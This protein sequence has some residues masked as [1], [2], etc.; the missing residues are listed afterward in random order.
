MNCLIN[1]SFIIEEHDVVPKNWILTEDERVSLTTMQVTEEDSYIS[2]QETV[3]LSL[4]ELWW[5][6]CRK[7]RITS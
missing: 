4:R 6:K 7:N 2:Q 1:L 5:K 3:E